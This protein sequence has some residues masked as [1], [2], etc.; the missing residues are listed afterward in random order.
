MTKPS[1][2]R[3]NKIKQEARMHSLIQL[4]VQQNL[5]VF[6]QLKEKDG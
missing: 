2:N 5:L 6:G 3:V 1:W 4:Q